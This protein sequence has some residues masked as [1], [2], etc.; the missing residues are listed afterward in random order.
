MRTKRITQAALLAA[1][2]AVL[3]HLQNILLPGSASGA[4]QFRA[5]EGLCV[6]A[7]FTPSAIW[8]LTVGCVFFNIAFLGA[9]PLDV[10]LGSLATFLSAG[11]MYLTRNIRA[12]RY[13]ALGMLLPAV[14]NGLLVGWELS[15]YMG[16]G[17]WP[18]VFYVAVG[19]AGVMLTLGTL[20][21]T[22]ICRRRLQKHIA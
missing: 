14:F 1:L 9:M 21:Y 2:Y 13:P 8:G 5:A 11:G 20:L 19:E 18:S 15:V 10:L 4:F 17:Y 6:L 12:F 16:G 7:F 3:T 22:V